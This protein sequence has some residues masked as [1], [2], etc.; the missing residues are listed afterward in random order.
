MDR[1]AVIGKPSDWLISSNVD[2]LKA[3]EKLNVEI[4]DI[5]IQELIFLSKNRT[6]LVPEEIYKSNFNKEEVKKAY[7]IYLALKELI[8]K[9][10]L[11]GLSVRCFDLLDTVRS[12]SCLAFALLNAEGVIA[13]CEGDVPSLLGMYLVRKHLGVSCFQSNPSKIDISENKIILAHCT[14]PLDMCERYEYMTHYESNSGIGIRGTLKV[15][16]ICIFRIDSKLEKYV[17]LHGKI[18]KNLEYE[19]LCRSQVDVSLKENVTYFLQRPLGNHHL[20][21]YGEDITPLEEALKKAD[22]KPII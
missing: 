8:K 12:T 22:L 15:G 2:Y 14:L 20:I 10:D 19:N 6:E 7:H 17:V 13:T 21:I 9:Y 3:K 1:L 16:P 5:D 11:Y 4:I 18:E